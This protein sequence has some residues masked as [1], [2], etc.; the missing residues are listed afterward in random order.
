MTLLDHLHPLLDPA[1]VIGGP[2]LAASWWARHAVRRPVQLA[3]PVDPELEESLRE[4]LWRTRVAGDET[5]GQGV[6]PGTYLEQIRELPGE[7]QGW[8]AVIRLR[9]GK[10]TTRTAQGAADMVCSAYELPAGSVIIEPTPDRNQSTARIQVITNSPLYGVHVWDPTTMRLDVATG[11]ARF[12]TFADGVEAHLRWFEPGSGGTNLLVAGAPGSGKSQFM[13]LLL[14]VSM[15]A[16]FTDRDGQERPQVETWLGCGQMGQSFP[17][18]TRCRALRWM[19]T[20]PQELVWMIHQFRQ[21]MIERSDYLTNLEWVDDKGRTRHGMA[22]WD[23]VASG[24]PLAQ[25]VIDEAAAAIALNPDIAGWLLDIARRGRKN[26][27]RVVIATQS[28]S[29]DELG[30][31]TNLRAMLSAG[32]VVVFR[33][34]DGN[35]S[36]MAFAGGEIGN[37]SEIPQVTPAGDP[38]Q[39][40][41]FTLGPDQRP[42]AMMRTLK[43]TDPFGEAQAAPIV[44]PHPV[45][46]S[47]G[48]RLLLEFWTRQE[49]RWRGEDP[50]PGELA[51]MA[52]EQADAQRAAL[53]GP[54]DGDDTGEP[55]GDRQGPAQRPASPGPQTPAGPD[56]R[57][58]LRPLILDAVSKAHTDGRDEVATAEIQQACAAWWAPRSVTNELAALVEAGVLDKPRKGKYRRVGAPV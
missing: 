2:A 8:E 3:P 34:G 25:L 45:D 56:D 46:A 31:N 43:I 55:V 21:T 23:P 16:R 47:G 4:Y 35:H 24:L 30:G 17:S 44:D 36:A 11:C 49:C 10:Q 5:T 15:R 12:G 6:L 41:C 19:A 22:E 14:G 58:A 48:G 20:T 27:M 1:L 32:G 53:D 28:P 40:A 54:G 52:K 57:P 51:R 50:E 26:G 18:W 7:L 39:G 42:Q 13:S 37:A 9:P 29:A 38:F 33:V